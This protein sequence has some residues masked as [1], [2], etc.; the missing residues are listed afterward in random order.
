MRRYS[1]G[2]GLIK[3]FEALLQLFFF[4]LGTMVLLGIVIL[5]FRAGEATF[6]SWKKAESPPVV[7]SPVFQKP[8][9][10]VK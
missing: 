10:I 4:L 8:E 2:I 3:A 7:E 9:L 5:F 1:F 6:A